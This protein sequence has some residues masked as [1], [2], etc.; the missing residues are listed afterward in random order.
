MLGGCGVAGFDGLPDPLAAVLRRSIVVLLYFSCPALEFPIFDRPFEPGGVMS[1]AQVEHPGFVVHA[2]GELQE[3]FEILGAKVQ[4]GPGA[5]E[6]EALIE[7]KLA[8]GV[9]PHMAESLA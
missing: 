2:V 6:V 7:R 3:H 9:L 4:L 1:V 8:F 5:A